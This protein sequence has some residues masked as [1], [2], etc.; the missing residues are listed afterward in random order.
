MCSLYGMYNVCMLRHVVAYLT[1]KCASISYFDTLLRE[2][3][4]NA[5]GNSYIVKAF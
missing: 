5:M 4:K 2:F 3:F 1:W